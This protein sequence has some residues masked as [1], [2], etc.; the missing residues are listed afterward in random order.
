[1]NEVAEDTDENQKFFIYEDI[2]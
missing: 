2:V 1:M